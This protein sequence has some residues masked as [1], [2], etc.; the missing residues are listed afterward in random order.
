MTMT[1]PLIFG[2][3]E[4]NVEYTERRAAYVVI[5]IP[6][7]KVAMVRV[8]QKYFLPGGGSLADEAPEETVAREVRE[9]LARSVRL[10][11]RIGEAIQ[12][13]YSAADERHYKM[14]AVFFTG[15]LK[16]EQRTVTG[17]HELLWLPIAE[18]EQTCFHAC[19]A[20]A[21]RQA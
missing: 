9:E 10:T 11:R 19:H 16:D 17:E 18:T 1:E 15:E 21:V 14:R 5:I 2:S 4:P 3:P 12:Y 7:G 6:D 13:F 20:W 8:R